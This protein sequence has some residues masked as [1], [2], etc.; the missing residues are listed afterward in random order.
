MDSRSDAVLRNRTLTIQQPTLQNMRVKAVEA[1]H[2]REKSAKKIA[3]DFRVSRE[4]L[5]KWNR[6]TLGDEFSVIASTVD[7][8]SETDPKTSANALPAT[9][10]LVLKYRVLP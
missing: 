5:Y 7:D 2:K 4:T 8:V 6:K 1:L 3:E 9:P 10:P